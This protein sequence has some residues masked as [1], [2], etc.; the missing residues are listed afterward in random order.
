[1]TKQTREGTDWYHIRKW[2]IGRKATM[3][4]EDIDR[5]F[6][7]LARQF[8]S[9]SGLMK[10]PDHVAHPDD[11]ALWKQDSM[12]PSNH[13]K[14]ITILYVCPMRHLC[15]CM[16]G[17]RVMKSLEHGWMLM[18]IC[19]FHDE[20]S[21]ASKPRNNTSALRLEEILAANAPASKHCVLVRLFVSN[22]WSFQAWL[23]NLVLSFYRHRHWPP[24]RRLRMA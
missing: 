10:V 20:T 6:F 9:L 23:D 21:H 7:E 1:M 14:H 16:A 3:E 12:F 18:D 19:G 5:E 4:Q 17:I 15:G 24:L 11:I 22:F 8:M 2:S 13:G